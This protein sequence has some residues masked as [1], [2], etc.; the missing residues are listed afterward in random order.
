M[1]GIGVDALLDPGFD[2]CGDLGGLHA[3]VFLV[4]DGL[5]EMELADDGLASL[6]IQHPLQKQKILIRSNF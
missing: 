1:S 5:E 4:G 6:L 3:G 2:H